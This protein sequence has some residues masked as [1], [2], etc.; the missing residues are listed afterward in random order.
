MPKWEHSTLIGNKIQFLGAG[1]FED[2]GDRHLSEV[3]AWDQIREE[4]WELVSVIVD[5]KSQEVVHY[6]KRPFEKRG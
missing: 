6:F 2:K 3:G 4:G 5:P 1:L